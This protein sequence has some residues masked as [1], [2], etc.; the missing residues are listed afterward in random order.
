MKC[1]KNNYNNNKDIQLSDNWNDSYNNNIIINNSCNTGSR[2][3]TITLT[4]E[5]ELQEYNSC[6][7]SK[8]QLNEVATQINK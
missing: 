8:V 7:I 4:L 6:L 1:R 5:E 3:I 2:A